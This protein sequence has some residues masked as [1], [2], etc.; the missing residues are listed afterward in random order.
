MGRK[1]SEDL[2]EDLSITLV[3]VT[4]VVKKLPSGK[5]S[6]LDKI[7]PETL[8]PLDKMGLSW[9]TRLFSVGWRS[10]TT[11]VEWQTG[12]VVLILRKGPRVCAPT[13]AGSHYS[14]S[15][16]NLLLGAGEEATS[17]C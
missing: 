15:P 4:R 14:A 8:K 1:E 17:D 6:G 5:A 13:T 7:H 11:P 3:E 16:G 2:M 10:G 12:M 9:L